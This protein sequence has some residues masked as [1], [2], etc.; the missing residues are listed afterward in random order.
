MIEE[1]VVLKNRRRISLSIKGEFN[2]EHDG[3]NISSLER[4]RLT[5]V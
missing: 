3:A 4:V 5:C 2:S 1:F